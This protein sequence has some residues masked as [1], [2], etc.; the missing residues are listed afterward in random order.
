MNSRNTYRYPVY[1]IAVT[2]VMALT[3]IV[4][5]ANA[6]IFGGYS[7]YYV[8]GREEQMASVFTTDFPASA[9][10][11]MHTVISI[12]ATGDNT[13]VYYDHWE[14]GYEFDPDDPENTYDIKYVLN[15]GDV[16]TLVGNNIPVFPRGTGV[17]FD[18]GDRL[19]TAGT[20]VTVSRSS[21]TEADGPNLAISWELFPIK[22]FLTD[23]TIPIGQ[24]VAGAPLFY[25]DFELVYVLVQSVSDNNSV[26]IDDPATP[27]VDLTTTLNRGE[28]TQ[29][30]NTNAGTHV[31]GTS[32]IQV[33][34]IVGATSRGSFEARG[35][36]AMP[37]SLWDTAYA[38]P[39][40][41]ASGG[42]DTDLY[43]YNP[44]TTSIIVEYA[45]T[46]GSGEFTI[47]A[48]ETRSYS[49]GAGR[50]VPQNS[51][52]ALNSDNVFWGIGSADT[53]SR[54]Y[55]WGFS[56]VPQNFLTNEYFLSWAPGTSDPTP[57]QNGSP[58]YVTAVFDDTVV[59]VDYSPTDGVPDVNITLDSLDSQTFFDPDNVNTG[60]HIWASDILA[61]AWGQDADAAGTSNPFLDLGTANLPMPAEW[62]DLTLGLTQTADP[63]VLAP[64]PGRTTTFTLEIK[65]YGYPVNS[66]SVK[67][68]LP[69]GF[70]YIA[71]SSSITFPDT[72]QKIGSAANPIVSGQ[73]LL[74]DNTIL[75]GLDMGLN[76]TLLV[77]FSAAIDGTVG[78][79]AYSNTGQAQ[80]TRLEGSQVFSPFDSAVIHVT[81]VTIDKDTDTPVVPAGGTATYRIRV[82]NISDLDATNVTISDTL[83][84]DTAVP[85][86]FTF[87][88][89]TITETN[90]SRTGTTNPAGG[91]TTLNW[92]TWT[93]NAGG[94]VE[95]VFDA[96]VDID[97]IPRTYDNTAA[98]NFDFDGSNYTI[99]DSGRVGQDQG[100]PS[101]TDPEDDEDVTIVSLLIDKDTTTSIVQAGGTAQ[102]VITLTNS[103][104]FDITGVTVSDDL[105]AGLTYNT[106]DTISETGATR[107]GTTNPTFGDT[108]PG[109]GT[110]TINP[111]GS[112]IITFTADVPTAVVP[113][114]YDNSAMAVSNE[115]GLIDDAGAV[116]QDTHTPPGEDP[117]DDE[118]ITI[119]AA[120][121]TID[122]DTLTP[123]AVR[124]QTTANY[125]ISIVN[126]GSSDATNVTISDVLPAGFSFNSEIGISETGG[127]IRTGITSP[128][129]GDTTLNWGTWTIPGGGS[130]AVTFAADVAIGVGAGVYDNTADA[131]STETGAIDDIGTIGYDDDTPPLEDPEDDED[132]E[133]LTVT[134]ADLGIDVSHTVEFEITPTINTYDILVTNYGPSVETATITVTDTLEPGLVYDA[135]SGTG[136]T[137]NFADPVLTCTN[138]LDVAPG[139]SLPPLSVDVT[140]D[141][142][143]V[144]RNFDNIASV[145]SPTN[146]NNAANNSDADPTTV[147][148]PDLSTSYKSVLDTNG[149]DVLPGDTLRYT[150]HLIESD[151]RAAPLVAVTDDLPANTENFN[152]R[153]DLSDAGGT[154]TYSPP[155]AGANNTGYLDVSGIAVP[156][157]TERLVVFEVDVAAGTPVGTNIDNTGVID[158]TLGGQVINADAPTLIVGS[159]AIPAQGPKPL[160]LHDNL[161]LDRTPAGGTEPAVGIADDATETWTLNPASVGQIIIDGSSG[162]IPVTLNVRNSSPAL[163]WHFITV[164][165]SYAGGSTGTIGSV[166]PGWRQFDDTVETVQYDVPI[167]GNITLNPNTAIVLSVYNN[168]W[169]STDQFEIW[170]YADI[171][172]TD[173]WSQVALES[174]SVINVDSVT[175]FDQPYP[176]GSPIATAFPG[177]TV[178]VRSVISDPFGSY[179]I[180]GA[181]VDLVDSEGSIQAD[182]AAMTQIADPGVD[183]KTY[184]YAYTFPAG[185][186]IDNWTATVTGIEGTEGAVTHSGTAVIAINPVT[187][188][189]LSITKF[190]ADDFFLNQ[191]GAFTISVSNHGPLDQTADIVVTDTIPAGMT[192]QTS[193]GT[194][195]TA[196]TSGLPTV[197]WTYPASPGSPV[198]AGTDLPPIT[199]TV[200]VEPTAPTTIQNTA[201]VALGVGE[202]N[203]I[204]NTSTDAVY[205]M[206][207]DVVKTAD[208]ASPYYAGDSPG[209][210]INYT[211]T[212]TNTSAVDIQ[213]VAVT[214]NVPVGS[215]YVPGSSQVNA[216]G[217]TFR[218]T[219]YY[220]GTGQF[221]GNTFELTLDQDLEPNYFLIVQG[222]GSD[223]GSGGGSTRGPDDNYVALTADPF[224]TGDLA[225]SS[226]PDRL[227]ITRRNN[228]DDWIGVLTVV[229]SRTDH[230]SNGFILRD[231]ARVSHPGTGTGG[232]DTV[233]NG[234]TDINQVLLM[235]G[236]NG[237]GCDTTETSQATHNSCHARIWPSGADT[238]NWSRDAGGT[239]LGTATSTVMAVEWGS[240]WNVQR[241]R[242]QGTSGAN[243]ANTA[244]AYTS[245]GIAGISRDNTWIWGTGHTDD[246]GIGDAGEAVL[247][248]L[249]DG[250]IQN[251]TENQVSIGIEYSQTMDF[252]VYALT[253]PN[254][255]TDYRFKGDGDGTL[256]TIN[257]A[258]DAATG[259]R[260]ALVTNGCNG[261]GTAYPRP[262]FSA[263]YTANDTV[264]LERRYSGQD[265]PAWVQGI[266]FSQISSGYVT[267]PGG[268]PPN[269]VDSSDGYNLQPGETLRVEFAVT[270]DNPFD[271]VAIINTALVTSDLSPVPVIDSVETSVRTLGQPTFTDDAGTPQGTFD[272][273]SEPVYLQVIDADRNA[274]PLTIE[275][276]T[277]TVYNPDTGDYAYP[278]LYETGVDTGIFA[279]DSNGDRYQLYILA[280]DDP[281]PCVPGTQDP[282]P[283]DDDV[284]YVVPESSPTL[285]LTYQDPADALRDSASANAVVITRVTLS[286]FRAYTDSGTTIVQWETSSEVETIGFNLYRYNGA[287]G[288]YVKVHAD[289]LPSLLS[290]IQ[291]G[292][293]RLVDPG[294][295]AGQSYT[296]RLEEIEAGG[297]HN[298]FGPFTVTVEDPPTDPGLPPMDDTYHR[299]AHA[300]DAPPPDPYAF[301]GFGPFTATPVA[302]L[303]DALKVSVRLPGLYYVDAVLLTQLGL[304]PGEVTATL[305]QSGFVI[306][307]QGEPV[308]IMKAPD[309]SGIYFYGEG[310]DSIYTDT[311]VYWIELGSGEAMELGDARGDVNGTG[312][313]ELSDAI[314]A[315]QAMAG[316]RPS[317]PGVRPNFPESGADVN[318]N[319]RVDMAEALF[320]MQQLAG[321][322]PGS[323]GPGPAPV[324][325]TR[326]FMDRRHVEVDFIPLPDW[327]NDPESDYWGWGALV[328]PSPPGSGEDTLTS[329]FYLEGFDPAGGPLTL[330]VQLFGATDTPP[331]PDHHVALYLNDQ[332]IGEGS[333][334]GIASFELTVADIDPA[335]VLADELNF[336]TIQ[337]LLD[338]G[339]PYSQ[340][341]VDSFDIAYPRTY[342]AV[343]DALWIRD[344]DE[345]VVTID[346]F[347]SPDIRVLDVTDPGRPQ[348]L[349]SITID[350]VNGE[351]QVSFAPASPDNTYLAVVASDFLMPDAVAATTRSQLKDTFPG[352]EY[353]VVTPREFE[354]V[355]RRLA[356]HRSS[357]GMTSLVASF[358]DIVDEFNHGIYHPMAIQKFLSHAYHNWLQPPRWVVLAGNGTYDY[359]G[360]ARNN[361][362]LPFEDN[363]IPTMMLGTARRLYPVD[364]LL[365]DAAGDDGIPDIAI[366]RLPAH[367]A[368]EL[369]DMV[370]KI[371]AYETGDPADW[372]NE[373]VML[374]DKPEPQADFSSDSEVVAAFASGAFS[375]RKIYL[376]D[377]LSGGGTAD[378]AS[379]DLISRINA[380]TGLVNFIGH[381]GFDR[382]SGSYPQ[383]S[384]LETGDIPSLTNMDR[385]P[386][387]AAMTCLAGY[388]AKPGFDSLGES[389]LRYPSGGAIAV[390]SPTGLSIN[391]NAKILDE[392]LFRALSAGAQGTLGEVIQEAQR[393][394]VIRTGDTLTPKIYNL[395]GDP[396]LKLRI[397]PTDTAAQ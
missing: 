325:G 118:D 9:A 107:T 127:A 345:A 326:S 135:Y 21:G 4:G 176:A 312:G 339:A 264:Q 391:D 29:L 94:S 88:S 370:D 189:D 236:F 200:L 396:A 296:Y 275:T 327:V 121:L 397:L 171:G 67:D 251:G 340:L 65:T 344:S 373:I 168:T 137:C 90:A 310:I 272:L 214:D 392:E 371:I 55:D 82:E 74:W 378:D 234:W 60:M 331:D 54:T 352:A 383:P 334:D 281:F 198:T 267:Q 45:D 342:R 57:T 225:V 221:G 71:N 216:P 42:F 201:S 120:V 89:A 36:N 346:G 34:F 12:T 58:A 348:R 211:I 148:L 319:N 195:W 5:P 123:F 128:G 78:I 13:T 108:S 199:L 113:G 51:G 124:G 282:F 292:I 167:A 76:E 156:P 26:Q 248:T 244:A 285:Q 219:E 138:D 300:A 249:G 324:G 384:L 125:I 182:D 364:T 260:M 77:T 38:N 213:N 10:A 360:R 43:L 115:S 63:T 280:C 187:G 134:T 227:Q 368:A 33:H 315:L 15:A 335:L 305:E 46:T 64:V 1:A 11:G 174:D 2:L 226:G 154:V 268:N 222:S 161:D 385:L 205:V 150:I 377:Y 160:Y 92:G 354:E 99:D 314:I 283:T 245:A 188:A 217:K 261:T 366:G 59:F 179:D 93:I 144:S 169:N 337:G 322:R 147:R 181:T 8:P 131:A 299:I 372:H 387:V 158:N 350:G 329:P 35:F 206:V 318:G 122:K 376:E 204:N 52:V 203:P 84:A 231:V 114:T 284:L 186:P 262:N 254:L 32:P 22:P 106:T 242:V 175:F 341:I 155:P 363:K 197:V 323:S 112:L 50:F 145:S 24:D 308:G 39:V 172:G 290:T 395:L 49:D 215:T 239:T 317:D 72:T 333:W 228:A 263:R 18:G 31:S 153:S 157:L 110:W 117:E 194:G 119:Q 297:T 173:A 97:I 102:Y 73:E 274:D 47:P 30:F 246:N 177:T 212:V 298:L 87:N 386:V 229:E 291:G 379:A 232:V 235:G 133:V 273:S 3:G 328:M 17:Y 166:S 162:T 80:G 185:G 265:F 380:G 75:D 223:G 163:I 69:P 382:F 224:G 95:I 14:D 85:P 116:A 28:T 126:A 256:L 209:D 271:P 183:T 237:A 101:G 255:A 374:A 100:A 140:V 338:T 184:E 139:A 210:T 98:A 286:D 240:D 351:Y 250:V 279:N 16:Q 146:D 238:I 27:F 86:G 53:E 353:I 277:V 309:N 149:G 111:G 130:V 258:V 96:D 20:S 357:Q 276:V 394:Y 321:L 294:A 104:A 68:I 330:T 40:S 270:L 25:S 152:Y 220:I 367:T 332:F 142:A 347:T 70:N 349:D 91:D 103:G 48:R 165:L 269:L 253:H 159:S 381:G 361:Y 19:Y 388:F 233:A 109:W 259:N 178:Y 358:E 252:E 7:E 218:V 196:D 56:L 393:T 105:P 191:N 343:N 61:V 207:R 369:S 266:D 306:R 320:V 359:R 356:D 180:T 170:P 132:V 307:H 365:A 287:V 193:S 316:G 243:G 44:N 389:L 301:L 151:G 278:T 83:P 241:V 66:I 311:N 288:Y 304:T 23:Y 302:T 136:W 390:W 164:T 190:H 362:G 141:P 247:I 313:V 289:L 37:D 143:A 295:L 375:T 129:I 257:V 336:L 208:V 79:G 202:N 192:Y 41:G 6:A 355:S 230:T 62:I 293:Y 81:A 303:G